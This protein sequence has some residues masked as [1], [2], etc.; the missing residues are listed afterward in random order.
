MSR[1]RRA[2]RKTRDPEPI[3][4]RPVGHFAVEPDDS[5][6]ALANSAGA[7]AP[8]LLLPSSQSA[9]TQTTGMKIYTVTVHEHD[10]Q[11]WIQIPRALVRHLGLKEGDKARWRKKR[12]ENA[13]ILSFDRFRKSANDEVSS[14]SK[15][16]G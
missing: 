12:G 16:R 1:M 5:M 4:V 9:S 15:K 7:H 13:F 8:R 10:G 6:V 3:P 11:Q 14:K 2:S